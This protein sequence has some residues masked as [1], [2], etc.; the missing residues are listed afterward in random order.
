MDKTPVL[1]NLCAIVNHSILDMEDLDQNAKEQAGF[2]ILCT[3]NASDFFTTPETSYCSIHYSCQGLCSSDGAH[4]NQHLQP[5]NQ[6]VYI[7]TI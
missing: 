6:I 2:V 5:Y 7:L 1:A 3:G 4:L